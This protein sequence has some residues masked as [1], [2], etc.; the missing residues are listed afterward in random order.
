MRPDLVV[1]P[2]PSI[3]EL[4]DLVKRREKMDIEDFVAIGTIEALDESVLIGLA[5]LD[6]EKL[7]AVLLAPV[8]EDL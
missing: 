2:H 6:V 3:G 1:G 8:D 5:G 4:T 7:D